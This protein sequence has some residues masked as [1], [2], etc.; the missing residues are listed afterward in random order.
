MARARAS[1]AGGPITAAMARRRGPVGREF[2]SYALDVWQISLLGPLE[3]RRDDRPFVVP[4]GKASELLVRLAIEAGVHVPAA[5]LVD[6]LWPGVVGARLNTLQAKVTLLRRALGDSRLIVSGDG[7]Y[8]LAV[9]PAAVDALA[10]VGQVVTASELLDAG[11]DRG[12]ADLCEATLRLFHGDLLPAAGDGQWV[13]PH[14]V[15]F[16]EARMRLL[17]IRFA[18]RSRLGDVGM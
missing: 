5:R 6:D 1:P 11:D 2:G 4:R 14:R 15:R 9:P 18:A 7:G 8:A 16:E 3:V 10:M 13:I 17:G 12:A